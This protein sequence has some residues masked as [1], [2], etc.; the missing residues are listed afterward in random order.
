MFTSERPLNTPQH[1]RR[2]LS[3]PCMHEPL[4]AAQQ[5]QDEQD[6]NDEA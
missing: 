6:D 3:L 5:Q 2:S 4:D 1:L